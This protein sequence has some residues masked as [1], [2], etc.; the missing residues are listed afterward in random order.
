MSTNVWR[1]VAKNME[2]GHFQWCPVSGQEALGANWNTQGA[3]WIS[4]APP[5]CV[6]SWALANCS[7]TFQ[8]SWRHSETVQTRSCATRSRWPCLNRWPPE[9]PA[10]LNH[11]VSINSSGQ[12]LGSCWEMHKGSSHAP[13]SPL[14]FVSWNRRRWITFHISFYTPSQEHCSPVLIKT[15]PG[16]A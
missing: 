3:S 9:V 1:E 2:L 12:W 11:T 8:S 7:E 4:E 10:N 16:R 15:E 6:G 13:T 5:Y 14:H